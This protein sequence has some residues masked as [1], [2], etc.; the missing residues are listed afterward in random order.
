MPLNAQQA[1]RKIKLDEHLGQD[2]TIIKIE[3]LR[4]AGTLGWKEGV[5]RITYRKK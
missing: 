2:I 5:Y 3:T 4:R 1:R